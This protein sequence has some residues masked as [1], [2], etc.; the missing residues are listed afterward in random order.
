MF[1]RIALI[2]RITRSYDRETERK[3]DG[4]IFVCPPHNYLFFCFRFFDSVYHINARLVT[5]ALKFGV[6][7][8]V[9]HIERKTCTHYSAAN[10]KHVRI[11][12]KTGKSNGKGVRSARRTNTAVLICS[13]GHT[14]T[15]SADE[16]AAIALAALY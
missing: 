14:D 6:Y 13:H 5:S 15:R 8:E 9:N 2:Y 16:Y 3:K 7:K 10:A 4:Q 1:I 11:I 12:V